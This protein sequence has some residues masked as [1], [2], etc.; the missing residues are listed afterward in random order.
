MGSMK[1]DE[2]ALEALRAGMRGAV[3]TSQDEGYDDARRVWNGSI[4][5]Y[6]AVIARCSGTA[7][8]VAAVRFA[9]ETAVE[10]AIRGGGHNIAGLGVCDDGLMIDLSLMK[11]VHVD[12]RARIAHVQG[13]CVGADVDR[14]T[15]LYGLAVPTGVISS[16]GI[17]GF[18]LGGGFGWMSNAYGLACDNLLEVEVVT[19]AGEVVRASEEE[20]ADLFWALRGGGGN[21]GIV[22]SFTFRLHELGPTVL[23]GLLAYPLDAVED[24]LSAFHGFMASAPEEVFGLAVLRNAPP[25]PFLPADI[26]GKPI[27]AL[28]LVHAGGVTEGERAL[29]PMR[30]HGT[31]IADAVA[32]RPYVQMQSLFDAG[33]A[34]GFQNYWKSQFVDRVDDKAI[35]LLAEHL[36]TMSSP[37]SDTKFAFLGGAVSRVGRDETAYGHRPARWIL[38]INSRWD[39]PAASADHIA[40]TRSYWDAMQPFYGEGVYVNFLGD[41]GGGRVEEAYERAV[42][43]RLVAVKNKWDPANFFH[44]NQNIRPS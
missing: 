10:V 1:V 4:Q 15:Q 32:P 11:G 13:G 7:D 23:S 9:H 5:K 24:A 36:R 40:W 35:A 3:L 25:A 26:V 29:A 21:F 41:E 43:E 34:P 27:L 42:Y 44:I 22:T 30:A 19:A 17:A 2:L 8:V 20:N 28:A 18:T 6:P 16:T 14:A 39:D 31:P 37:I 12:P 33:A 38:N